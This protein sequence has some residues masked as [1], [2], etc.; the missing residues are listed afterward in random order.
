[1]GKGIS[2]AEARARLVA[3]VLA[4]S[5]E[6]GQALTSDEAGWLVDTS[7]AGALTEDELASVIGPQAVPAWQGLV[8]LLS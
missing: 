8:G 1:M 5:I 4:K 7:I 2:K 6:Q 3:V